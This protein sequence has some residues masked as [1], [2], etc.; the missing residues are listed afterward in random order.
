MPR[1]RSQPMGGFRL[2]HG[3][4]HGLCRAYS[5][6]CS[7]IVYMR[8]F[9]LAAAAVAGVFALSACKSSS[10]DT[11]ST[12]VDMASDASVSASDAAVEA[13]GASAAAAD[14]SG[15]SVDAAG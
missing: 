14:A 8:K 2:D 3:L 9:V 7:R 4:F 5:T 6:R 13:S 10:D 1:R 11:A 15:A 12:A